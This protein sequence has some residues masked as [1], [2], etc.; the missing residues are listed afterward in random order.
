MDDEDELEPLEVIALPVDVEAFDVDAGGPGTVRLFFRPGG[1][2]L[3]PGGDLAEVVVLEQH[4]RVAVALRRRVLVGDGPDDVVYGG[5]LLVRGAR[6]SLDVVLR[7]PLGDRPVLDA[8]S[9]RE[10]PRVRR[11]AGGGPVDGEE[12][13]TPRWMP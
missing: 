11:D 9:G 6:T 5:E 4:D 1:R 10:V 12:H 13:G 8:A 7:E 3:W 2:D